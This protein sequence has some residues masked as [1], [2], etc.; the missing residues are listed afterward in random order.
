MAARAIVDLDHLS[1]IYE[2]EERY[3]TS[4]EAGYCRRLVNYVDYT[5]GWL[6]CD[7]YLEYLRGLRLV[8]YLTEARFLLRLFR[9]AGASIS[10]FQEAHWLRYTRPNPQP[11]SLNIPL[12]AELTTFYHGLNSAAKLGFYLMSSTGLRAAD[13][14]RLQY[15]GI[16]SQADCYDFY[17]PFTKNGSRM[18]LVTVNLQTS[19]FPEPQ[20]AAMVRTHYC[21]DQ[22]RG[23]SY[24]WARLRRLAP[25]RLHA[26]RNRKAIQLIQQ[27]RTSEEI[28][29][30]LLWRDSRSLQ[31]YLR[32]NRAAILEASS[33][34]AAVRTLRGYL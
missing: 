5:Q 9:Y 14:Q 15:R 2:R 19:E 25:F 18:I 22:G 28:Q 13:V 23:P 7:H 20:F 11:R 29:E 6:D 33:V 21:H 34:D 12:L 1:L 30:L 32:L 16:G 31:R 27:A 3:F 4:R 8:N 17:L 10:P 26:L 24:P